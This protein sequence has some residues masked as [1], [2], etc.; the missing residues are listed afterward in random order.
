MSL[1]TYCERNRIRCQVRTSFDV[2]E[3]MSIFGEIGEILYFSIVQKSF[4]AGSLGSQSSHDEG[5]RTGRTLRTNKT[6]H[7]LKKED[8]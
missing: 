8:R 3:I 4:F 7:F 2:C 6:K 1:S 5:M